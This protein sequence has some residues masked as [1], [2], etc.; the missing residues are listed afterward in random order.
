MLLG[1]VNRANDDNGKLS[2]VTAAHVL[3]D[4]LLDGAGAAVPVTMGTGAITLAEGLRPGERSE[5]ERERGEADDGDRGGGFDGSD[6]ER[7][8]DDEDRGDAAIDNDPSTR[9]LRTPLTR[10]LS[11]SWSG[12][13]EEVGV[14]EGEGEVEDEDEGEADSA[15]N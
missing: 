9:A 4:T 14:G 8:K 6:D 7:F 10:S 5:D 3:D 12:V 11:T 2:V 15:L 1:R 13:G